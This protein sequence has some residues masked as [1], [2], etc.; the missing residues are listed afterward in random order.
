MGSG[1]VQAKV[2]GRRL[3]ARSASAGQ[4]RSG[5]HGGDEK[6]D[7][8]AGSSDVPVSAG[9]ETNLVGFGWTNAVY[10]EMLHLLDSP[11]TQQP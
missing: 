6:Y 2:V 5:D 11:V 3:N 1:V 4:P 8:V 10:L 7:A 9:Y